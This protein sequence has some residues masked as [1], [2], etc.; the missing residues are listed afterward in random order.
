MSGRR[1]PDA[2]RGAAAVELALILPV[3]LLL[4]FGVL[5]WSLVL[6]DD[7]TIASATRTG[8]RTASALP[9][10]PDFAEATAQAVATAVGA[11]PD[12]AVEELWIYAAGANGRPVG[13][14]DFADCTTC[15]KFRWDGSTRAFLRIAGSTWDPATQNACAG[16]SDAVGVRLQV[17][18]DFVAGFGARTMRLT[19]HTV[20]RLEP[21]PVLQGCR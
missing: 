20:M 6:R 3:L 9:R 16:Q 2:E 19:D 14:S 5:E 7:L 11:L 18:H 15:V 10:S 21:I 1:G 17:R 8:A 4:L 12:D 13:R